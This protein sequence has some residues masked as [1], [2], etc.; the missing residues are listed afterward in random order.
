M[1]DAKIALTASFH[2]SSHSCAIGIWWAALWASCHALC[3]QEPDLAIVPASV[4]FTSSNYWRSYSWHRSI[5]VG[6]VLIGC[7]Y[8]SACAF[9]MKDSHYGKIYFNC[10]AASSMCYALR[11]L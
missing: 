5:D 8:N 4:L 11:H 3:I 2:M 10:I 7:A 1:F 6:T 9:S